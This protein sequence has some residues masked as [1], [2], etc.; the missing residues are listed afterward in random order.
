MSNVQP[1]VRTTGGSSIQTSDPGWVGFAIHL[2]ADAE[3]VEKQ[4]QILLDELAATIT[5]LDDIL[6]SLSLHTP[7][8]NTTRIVGQL[9]KDNKE[10]TAGINNVA[11][12]IRD[13]RNRL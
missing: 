6:R 4:N 13:A 1:G 11:K 9:I 3:A 5:K 7:F 8:I 12:A 10:D 2:I